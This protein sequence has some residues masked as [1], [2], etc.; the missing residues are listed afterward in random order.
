MRATILAILL[1]SLGVSSCKKTPEPCIEM[2]T[3]VAPTGQ[4]VIFTSCSE[5]A[6]SYEWFMTGPTGA[7]ENNL[8]WSDPQFTH[9]FTVPGTY[10][11]SLTAYEDFSWLGEYASTETTIVIN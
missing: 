1:L 8:G 2:S 5:K 10:T 7:P 4:D 9:S 11:I 6:L 3:S